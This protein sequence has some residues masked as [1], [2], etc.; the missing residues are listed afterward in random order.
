MQDCMG[1]H[2]SAQ[3][4]SLRDISLPIASSVFEKAIGVILTLFGGGAWV[5]AALA[6]TMVPRGLHASRKLTLG[7]GRVRPELLQTFAVS[8]SRC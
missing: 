8:G 3:I 7:I 2:V 1:P 6:T 4:W 5:G